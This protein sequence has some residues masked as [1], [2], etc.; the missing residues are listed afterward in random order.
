[1]WIFF[2]LLLWQFDYSKCEAK[3]SQKPFMPALFLY[4]WI[5][6]LKKTAFPVA[7]L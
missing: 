3:L 2:I 5:M 7:D 4:Q 6:P 1:M